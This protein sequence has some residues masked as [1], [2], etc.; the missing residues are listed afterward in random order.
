MD[1]HALSCRIKSARR[2]KR[3]VKTDRD[4]QLI[5]LYKRRKELWH[6]YGLLPMVPIKN[7]YQSG[8]KRFFVLRE[9]V[10][11]SP[12]VEFYEALLLK[13]NTTQH[14]HEKSFKRKKRRKKRYGFEERKQLLREFDLYW[15]N[16]TRLNLSEQERACF[17]R[18]ETYSVKTRRTEVKYVF[19]EPWRYVLKVVPNMITHKKL[20]D[21]DLEKEIAW[22]DGYIEQ[23][24]LGPRINTL[25]SG[26]KYNCYRWYQKRAKY[27]NNFKN[28]PRYAHKEVYLDLTT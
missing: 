20:L 5:Q 26:K 8:W 18:V 15:W 22:I 13:I 1:N 14:H 21:V 6:Q 23:N 2:K 27:I 19:A 7:P 3:L 9:D 28:I 4:K 12:R 16:S 17:T 25:T 10:K 24:K 11:H